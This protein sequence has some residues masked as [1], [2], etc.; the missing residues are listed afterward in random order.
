MS[1]DELPVLVNNILPASEFRYW[2]WIELTLPMKDGDGMPIVIRA[3]KANFKMNPFVSIRQFVV[4]TFLYIFSRMPTEDEF[5][6]WYAGLG[7]AFSSSGV[8]GFLIEIRSRFDDLFDSGDYD[9]LEKSVYQNVSDLYN[10]LLG[11]SP[12]Q[13]ERESL[14]IYIGSNGL[15]SAM[16][17]LRST[18]ECTRRLSD[19]VNQLEFLSDVKDMSEIVIAEGRVM[20]NVNFTIKNRDELYS[21]R[22]SETDRNLSPTKAVVGRAFYVGNEVF[23]SDVLMIGTVVFGEINLSE[24]QITVISDTSRQGIKVVQEISQRCP[25]IYKGPGCDTLDPSPTCSRI[26]DDAINGC[27]SKIPAPQLVNGADD[28]R[29]SFGGVAKLA[30]HPTEPVGTG[31]GHGGGWIQLPPDPREPIHHSPFQ[32]NQS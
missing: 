10:S 11:R 20:D 12:T 29:P 26:K 24:F 8:N 28:N 25:L 1:R 31:I 2:D 13:V 5:D 17:L 21:V 6:D 7:T 30:S 27:K 3:S 23:E 14:T 16:H 18:D 4:E 19:V 22:F 9:E 15:I 32:P